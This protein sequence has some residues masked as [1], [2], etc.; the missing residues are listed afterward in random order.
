MAAYP[1][2]ADMKS[3]MEAIAALTAQV[4]VITTQDQNLSTAAGNN[5]SAA[6][7]VSTF[8]M[9]PDKLKVE[10]IIDYSD[11]FGL[12]LWKA[13]IEAFPIKFDMKAA[14]TATFVEGM[15]VKDREF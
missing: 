14:G 8:A 6:T 9:T 5:L 11:K 2:P 15:K 12:S 1:V 10:E 7:T 3:M 4:T 13:A